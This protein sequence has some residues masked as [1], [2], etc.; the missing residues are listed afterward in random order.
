MGLFGDKN[1]DNLR[2]M[3]PIFHS[4]NNGMQIIP[5]AVNYESVLAYLEGLS[6]EEYD[7]VVSVATIYRDANKKAATALGVEHEPTTFINPPENTELIPA[8][9]NHKQPKSFLDDDEDDAD[10]ADV[11]DLSNLEAT[12]LPGKK[13][14]LKIPV[15]DKK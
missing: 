15:K 8:H 7:K 9:I 12:K 13:A 11:L 6:D 2:Q 5:A 14:D 4:E 10:I 1:K 3:P